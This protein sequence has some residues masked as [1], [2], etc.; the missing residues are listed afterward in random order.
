[1]LSSSHQRSGQPIRPSGVAR[2]SAESPAGLG[3]NVAPRVE[4]LVE[5]EQLGI[6]D[7]QLARSALRVGSP[8]APLPSGQ[9]SRAAFR[10]GRSRDQAGVGG[11]APTPAARSIRHSVTPLR[12][13]GSRMSQ[14]RDAEDLDPAVSLSNR[15]ET[16][17]LF[18]HPVFGVDK[19]AVSFPVIGCAPDGDWAAVTTRNRHDGPQLSRS[20]SVGIGPG[21]YP[22]M[23]GVADIPATGQQWA[24]VELNPSRV[25]D[26]TG[27]SVATAAESV[28]AVDAAIARAMS[29]SLFVPSIGSVEEANVK[30]LDVTRDFAGVTD[31]ASLIGGLIGV[32]RAYGRQSMVYF[33][34]ARKGAQTLRVGGK[35]DLVLLYDKSAETEGQAADTV[36]FESR[37][38]GWAARYGGI[39][40][41]SDLDDEH[42]DTLGWDRFDWSGMGTSVESNVGSVTARVCAMGLSD[43]EENG[44][45]GYLVKRATGV[46]I[47]SSR[48]TQSK[49][50]KLAREAGV[51]MALDGLE[52]EGPGIS[53]RLDAVEGRAV[54]E[55]G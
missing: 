25:W 46:P 28:A 31:A 49:Y 17:V 13:L 41:V 33:D 26:P 12:Y 47:K 10:P 19:I 40:K 50:R 30:R 9:S 5:L 42:V 14:D 4:P 20:S 29:E 27:H 1:M 53:V 2:S 16:R 45:L 44:L 18:T 36:R 54:V 21:N 52:S 3:L 51:A 34:P 6:G 55:L 24:K 8:V 35:A 43:T 38:R 15:R 23:I 39:A 7:G 32:H 11:G 22:A 37:C 48:K